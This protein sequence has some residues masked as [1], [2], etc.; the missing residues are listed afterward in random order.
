MATSHDEKKTRTQDTLCDPGPPVVTTFERETLDEKGGHNGT[1]TRPTQDDDA[2][3]HSFGNSTIADDDDVERNRPQLERTFTP[4]PPPVKVPRS[5]RRGLF[6]RFAL[7][8]EVTDP[9]DYNRKVKWFITAIVAFSAIAAPAGSNIFFPALEQV[10]RD[11][12][13]TETITNLSVSLYMLSMA[14]F[15]LWWSAFSEAAGRRTVY[16]TSF[17]IF[18]LFACLAAVSKSIGMLIVM[19]ML[20]G[21]AAASVQAVGAGTIAD[22]W[23]VRERGRAMG[24]F[25]LG[26]LMGPLIAPILGGLIA[27]RWNWRATLWTVAIYGLITWIFIFFALPETLKS[28]KNLAEEAAAEET[29]SKATPIRPTLSRRSTQEVV[30][31]RS[32]QYLTKVR[33][34]LI[35]PLKALAYLRFP[36]VLLTV[37]YASVTFGSLY[38]LNVSVQYNFAKKPYEFSTIIIGLMYI[39][40]SIGYI[41]A[42]LVCGRWMDTI[43]R[44]EAIRANRIDENGRLKYVPEDR[45]RENAW[46]G[47]I[48]YPAALIWY[49]WSV[50]KGVYWIVPA[51]ANF[52]Y[53][54]GSMMIFAMATTMLT[55]FMPKKSSSGVAVN[56]FVRN[57]FSCIGATVGVPLINSIGSGWVF[58]ILGIWAASSSAVIWAMRRFGPRWR[59]SMMRKLDDSTQE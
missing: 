9:V 35:D 37:Y 13:T 15:P 30:A 41:S 44:R 8:A 46:L 14:I 55:E 6:A 31:K 53:G 54:V 34:I 51:I 26:P 39:P 45:M 4:R 52:F 47:A 11:L 16:L 57:I 17:A 59:L 27:Q 50:D 5:K 43:M 40:S 7:V 1:D 29:Q 22:V 42:S 38:L 23:E 56:N 12:N 25:Y 20:S 10:T 58:T 32:K 48:L 49:G 33:I 36:A 3:A 2:D 24:I 18:I 28:T 21:G 19:R